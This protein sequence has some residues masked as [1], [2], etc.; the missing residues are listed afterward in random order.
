MMLQGQLSNA[1]NVY[2]RAITTDLKA[3]GY[4]AENLG[5][6]RTCVANYTLL[7]KIGRFKCARP[8]RHL[9]RIDLRQIEED[10]WDVDPRCG[11]AAVL[12]KVL[13]RCSLSESYAHE[14]Q[15]LHGHRFPHFDQAC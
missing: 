13:L 4:R 1:F 3:W 6:I 11:E 5:M 2:H 10:F 7:S 15:R 14:G 12:Y 9:G 8:E